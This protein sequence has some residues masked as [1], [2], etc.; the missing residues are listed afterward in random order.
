M[1]SHSKQLLVTTS[2]PYANGDIH[3]GHLVENIQADIW[4]RFQRLQGHHCLFISGSD[5]HGTPVM[6]LAEKQGIAP[7]VLVK[8]LHAQHAQDFRDFYVHH[9]NF[10]LTHSAENQ[11][12]VLMIYQR[13]QQQGAITQRTVKQ[14]Y[15]TEKALFLPDRFVKGTCPR[16]HA[17]DQ[18]GDSCEQCGATYSPTE[19][20]NPRSVLSGATPVERESEHYFFNL[21]PQQAA[22]KTW[23]QDGHLQ[24]T[25]AKKMLEWFDE[26]LREWDISRDAPYFGFG[27]PDAPEKYFYVWLDAPIGYLAATQHFC[28]HHPGYSF[29]AYWQQ[30]S[31]VELYQFI[32]KDIIYFHAL[33]WPALLMSAHLRLPTALFVNGFLTI[34]GQKL[35]KSRGTFINART[36]LNH[37]PPEFFRYYL[38][39]KLNGHVEDIDFNFTDFMARTNADLI[40]KLVNIASRT[41]GFIVK[42]FNATLSGTLYDPS[43]WQQALDT[44]VDIAQAYEQR[45]FNRALRLVMTLADQTN[46]YIAQQAPWQL[47][48]QADQQQQAHGVCSLALNIFRVLMIYLKPVLPQT[49]LA[50]EAFLNSPCERWSDHI[51]P[52]LNH[53]INEFIPLLQRIELSTIEALQREISAG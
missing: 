3:L 29:D 53:K 14:A 50:A 44:G 48:K 26:D 41:A 39:S 6:L 19:L 2:L 24:A 12:L 20:K 43:R 25:V 1:V 38:A 47:I 22:L 17:E 32:G 4:V 31:T 33:F 52:L 23:I 9:D 21:K 51:T 37:L 16:C 27:I 49:A 42:H 36:Y 13:L 30:D 18:Y 45:D 11:A 15:D 40:G 34:N 28:N 5:C 8:Q 46:H 7:E 35:S 10:Y